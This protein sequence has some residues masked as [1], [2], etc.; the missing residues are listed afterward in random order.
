MPGDIV[1]QEPGEGEQAGDNVAGYGGYGGYAMGG[2]AV[3]GE[4]GDSP[5]ADGGPPA[6]YGG[7]YFFAVHVEDP[8]APDSNSPSDKP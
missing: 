1:P 4:S 2:G 5:E 7:G 6:G 3:V 8:N